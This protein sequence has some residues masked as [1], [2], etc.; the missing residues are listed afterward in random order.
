LQKFDKCFT[1]SQQSAKN[2]LQNILEIKVPKLLEYRDE[3]S[4]KSGQTPDIVRTDSGLSR[5]SASASVSV[6]RK[7]AYQEE[8]SKSKAQ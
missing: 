4:K 1:K 2:N 8:E 3:Y 7:N 6:S 5:A